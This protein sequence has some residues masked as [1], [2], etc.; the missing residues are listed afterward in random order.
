MRLQGFRWLCLALLAL[1]PAAATAQQTTDSTALQQAY[2]QRRQELVKEL[3][4]TQDELASLRA[5]RVKLE[6]RIEAAL[7]QSMQQRA[8]ALLLSGQQNALLQLDNMLASAQENMTAQR[9]RMR[10]LGDA[11]RRRS[12]AVL[13]VLLRADSVAPSALGS[14]DLQLDNASAAIRTYSPMAA[15]ALQQGA[16]DQLYRSEVLPTAHVVRLN[17]TIAGQSVS[18]S[19]NVNAQPETVTY[20]QFMV[21]NGQLVP[22]SWT[23]QGTTPQ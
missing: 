3:Q 23:S 4:S 12:G 6:A 5:Q 16:V 22:T 14:F 9:D 13:V 1:V 17:A 8:Q 18:Q 15:T 2:E 11:V 21:R 7:A 10:A 20:V 19:V